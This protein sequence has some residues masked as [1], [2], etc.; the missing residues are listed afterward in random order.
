MAL[1]NY[2]LFARRLDNLVM[3]GFIV[4]A[5]MGSLLKMYSFLS[6]DIVSDDERRNITITANFVA[7]GVISIASY[8]LEEDIIGD[9]MD[10]AESFGRRLGIN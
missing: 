10:R 2:N 7:M 3:G 6:G 8:L 9:I 5:S 1:R 4:G